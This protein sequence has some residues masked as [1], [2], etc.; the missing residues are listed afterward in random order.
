[1]STSKNVMSFLLLF[2]SSPQQYWREGQNG[3]CMDER[4]V[5]GG[6]ERGGGQGGEMTQTVYAHMNK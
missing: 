3:F 6:E 5:W 4:M 2:M 1:M